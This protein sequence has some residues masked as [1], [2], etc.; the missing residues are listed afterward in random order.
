MDRRPAGSTCKFVAIRPGCA[1]CW[2]PAPLACRA[3]LANRNRKSTLQK[4]FANRDQMTDLCTALA[5]G[6]CR[7]LSGLD[8]V[9]GF[10]ED[11]EVV[12]RFI[13][14]QSHG[15]GLALFI[16]NLDCAGIVHHS[17]WG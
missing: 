2:K 8:R 16:F 1:R 14:I 7:A 3:Q 15:G 11:F 10:C 5:A 6:G 9:P 12:P 17:S 13:V 4:L